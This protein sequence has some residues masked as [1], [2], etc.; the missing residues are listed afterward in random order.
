MFWG[1]NEAEKN[2]KN[3]QSDDPYCW[4]LSNTTI[5]ENML[6]KSNDQNYNILATRK[7][8]TMLYP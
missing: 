8:L 7:P 4:E 5:K 2:F 1:D 6:Y 3:S